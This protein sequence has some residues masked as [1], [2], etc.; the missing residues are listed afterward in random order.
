MI[1]RRVHLLAMAAPL[2]LA[3]QG[4]L[5]RLGLGRKPSGDKNAAGIKE[6][7][8]TG[9]NNAV[10]LAG[11]TD[12]YFAHAVIKILLPDQM[13]PVEKGLR[14]VGAG[15]LIDN[16]VLGMNRAAEQAAPVAKGIFGDT[17]KQMSIADAVQILRGGDTSATDFFRKTTSEKLIAAFRPP[18]TESMQS[19]GAVKTYDDVMGRFRRIPLMK[20]E[21]FDINSYVTTQAVNGLFYLVGEEEKQIRTNPAARVTPLL[22]EVFGALR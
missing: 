11:K 14:L 13:K 1:T 21:P 7:L 19:V 15:K 17:I 20:A 3:A 9:L 18:I 16:L 10:G 22:K 6:A 8:L 4:I 12:G 5:D 2:P